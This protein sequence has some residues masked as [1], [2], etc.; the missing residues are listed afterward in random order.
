MTNYKKLDVW[1]ES[2]QLVKE[3]YALVKKYPKEELYGL[4]SQARR[5]AVSIPANIAE[6]IGRG[7]K[8]ETVQ[9][10]HIARG[11]AYETEA[12]LEVA[13]LVGI[14]QDDDVVIANGVIQKCLQLINGTIRY[15][16]KSDSN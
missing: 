12:L 10:L 8:K 9:F 7:H 5:A 1:K 16:E 6:G 3:V 14:L 13:V 2:M 15:Y 11:S 4:S